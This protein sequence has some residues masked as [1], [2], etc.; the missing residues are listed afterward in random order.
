[1]PTT[2]TICSRCD[3]ACDKPR[4]G[5]CACK[6]SGLDI[7]VH[8]KNR[9]CPKG[10]HA[11][12]DVNGTY[13]LTREYGVGDAIAWLLSWFIA[14]RKGCGCEKRRAWLNRVCPRWRRN[15]AP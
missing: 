15:P 3:F 11:D 2:A 13:T 8:I 6:V 12:A 1:M 10:F 7:L 14:P 9:D 4:S 5:P